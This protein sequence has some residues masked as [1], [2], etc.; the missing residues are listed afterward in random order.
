MG[1]TKISGKYENT[2]KYYWST[3]LQVNNAAIQSQT[4]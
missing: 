1:N 3:S 2:T 4:K